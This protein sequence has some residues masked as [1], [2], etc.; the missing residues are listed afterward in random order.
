MPWSAIP[1][2]SRPCV[3]FLPFQ[4]RCP[5]S[6][7]YEVSN[8]MLQATAW[9]Y[10]Q[11]TVSDIDVAAVTAKAVTDYCVVWGVWCGEMTMSC[12]MIAGVRGARGADSSPFVITRLPAARK[13]GICRRTHGDPTPCGAVRSGRL[14]GRGR[15]RVEEDCQP[16]I[17][18]RR[19]CRRGFRGYGV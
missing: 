16:A 14:P 3:L 9:L 13:V 2:C 7:W 5:I 10:R 8:S 6:K 1:S 15:R 12:N 4:N 11:S 17:G 19:P 18:G